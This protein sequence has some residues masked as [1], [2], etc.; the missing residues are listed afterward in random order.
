MIGAGIATLVIVC[1]FAAGVSQ[2]DL[3][4]AASEYDKNK[5]DAEKEGLFFTRE[6]VEARYAIA[7]TDNGAM[8]I[9]SV[10]PLVRNLKID[11][12]RPFNEKSVVAHWAEIK[13][14]VGTIDEA[15][16]RKFLMFKRDFSNPA[17]T[18]FP[19]YSGVKD[20]VT[21]FVQLGHRAIEQGEMVNAE[22]YWELA[23]YLANAMDQEGLLIG[24]LVRIASLAII[25][26]EIQLTIRAHGK[27]PSVVKM[28]DKVLTKLDK[29]Y[30][31]KLPIRME[32]WFGTSMIDA[33]LNDPKS[34]SVMGSGSA[35]PR[36]I[37]YG[38]YLPRFKAANMSRIH[39]FYADA[40]HMVPTNCDDLVA[41]QT[42]FENMDKSSIKKGLSYTILDIVGPVFGATGSA[43]ARE[44]AQR[45]TL[46]QAVEILKIGADPAAGL[47]LKG[48][49]AMDVDGKPIRIKKGATGW[50]I[51]S[52]GMDKVDDGGTDA[53]TGKGDYVVHMPR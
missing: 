24:V 50:L 17:A 7:E 2:T 18:L 31:L 28:L 3:S 49:F 42:A 47:P 45:N 5:A 36:E 38:K 8:L 43:V 6:Q 4:Q 44:I 15:S 13:P 33:I 12:Q 37:Q 25:D 32:H 21:L 29:P 1:G 41:V 11:R 30:D 53:V 9:Q 39:R 51:Y 46:R 10:L 27:D 16:H 40:A 34:Y 20:W 22:K 14:A 48:R 52:V 23:A 19:E 35:V 26:R